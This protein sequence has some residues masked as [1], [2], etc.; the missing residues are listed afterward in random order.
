M[1]GHCEKAQRRKRLQE[2]K[3]KSARSLWDP[4]ELSPVSWVFSLRETVPVIREETSQKALRMGTHS[5]GGSFPPRL[6]APPFSLSHIFYDKVKLYH[7]AQNDLCFPLP[8]YNSLLW[9]GC[10]LLFR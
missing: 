6:T 8:T 7:Y 2:V 10:F 3:I 9:S 1:L 5:L 4:E